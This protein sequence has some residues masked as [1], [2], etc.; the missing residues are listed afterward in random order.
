MS[1]NILELVVV[2]KGR[3]GDLSRTLSSIEKQG[4]CGPALSILIVNGEPSDCKGIAA[5]V[6]T[7]CKSLNI[8]LVNQVSKGI[9]PAMNEGVLTSSS[10]WIQFVNSGDESLSLE[11]LLTLLSSLNENQVDGLVGRSIVKT[12]KGSFVSINP[13]FFP[14]SQSIFLL[15]RQVLPS[16]FSVCHQSV[17]FSR[18]FHMAHLYQDLC[19]AS[20]AIVIHDLLEASWISCPLLLSCFYTDGVSSV[21]PRS[22]EDFRKLAFSCIRIGYYRRLFRLTIK[23]ILFGSL[24]SQSLDIVRRIRFIVFSLLFGRISTFGYAFRAYLK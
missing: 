2:V 10:K 19:I 6:S 8:K 12:C 14:L 5:V 3:L 18:P 4:I 16:I 17:V 9:F 1:A 20:D 15:M 22:F 21:A 23:F 13:L 7:Y 24:P 11:P